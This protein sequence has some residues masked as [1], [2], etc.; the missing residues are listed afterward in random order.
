MNFFSHA[1]A[2]LLYGMKKK[3][4]GADSVVL[5]PNFICDALNQPLYEIK[6]HIIYYK[7]NNKMEPDW[8]YLYA[9]VESNA[10]DALIMVHYF[11][12]SQNIDKFIRMCN[13]YSIT[14]I[15][16]N[17]HGFG[18]LYH[19]REMG[20]YGVIGISS[21]R[22]ILSIEAGGMLYIDGK[23]ISPPNN[24]AKT[25]PQIFKILAI[26]MINRLGVVGSLFF[27]CFRVDK[28][29]Y[30]TDDQYIEPHVKLLHADFFSSYVINRVLGNMDK[31]ESYKSK[32]LKRWNEISDLVRSLGL[33]PVYDYMNNCEV[34]WVFPFYVP[35]KSHKKK[36]YFARKLG[37]YGV[38]VFPWPSLPEHIY[39]SEVR[40][41]ALELRRIML[42]A[43][44]D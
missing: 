21:P 14:L 40:E 10:V 5:V 28:A 34:P 9:L 19:G 8:G 24:L 33:E 1:R 6:C 22:K 29:Y 20:T 4:I 26:N 25:S 11:G 43:K 30:D 31:F 18:G 7:I 37:L 15:E 41:E 42:C 13:D 17:A 35:R 38:S 2:A 39:P 23:L 16:D 32:R 12:K 27:N 3:N 36:S 44:I